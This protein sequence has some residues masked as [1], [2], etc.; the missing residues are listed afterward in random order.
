MKIFILDQKPKFK[1]HLDYL[2]TRKVARY[3][4]TRLAEKNSTIDLSTTKTIENINLDFLFDYK[5]FPDNIM[6][7]M[8]QWKHDNRKMT[9]GDTIVQQIYVPP[10]KIFSQKI[11][12][13]VG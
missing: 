4:K 9:V 6:T 10:I 13:G 8:T 7:F 12:L 3:D 1:I 5:V 11:I 2:K